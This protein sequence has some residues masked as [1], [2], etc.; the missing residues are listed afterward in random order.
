MSTKIHFEN[1]D[2]KNSEIMACLATSS[3]YIFKQKLLNFCDFK[4]LDS[5]NSVRNDRRYAGR[6]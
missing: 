6:A 3:S 1:E 2:K 5:S 4:F